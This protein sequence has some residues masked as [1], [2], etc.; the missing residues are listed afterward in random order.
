MTLY[1]LLHLCA[2]VVALGNL[3]KN[4]R[5]ITVLDIAIIVMVSVPLCVAATIVWVTNK[6]NIII[7]KEKK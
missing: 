7:W 5:E 3:A 6:K 4:N 1:I 2:A